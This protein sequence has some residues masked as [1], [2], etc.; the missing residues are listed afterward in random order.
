MGFRGQMCPGTLSCHHVGRRQAH[1]PLTFCDPL[2][3]KTMTS[4][5]SQSLTAGTVWQT[6]K[7]QD[8][9]LPFPHTRSDVLLIP[10]KGERVFPG[11]PKAEVKQTSKTI[12]FKKKKPQLLI[13]LRLEPAVHE[14][15]KIGRCSAGD[16]RLFKNETRKWGVILGS[17]GVGLEDQG[18]QTCS[19]PRA[20]ACGGNCLPPH[21][22]EK[23]A[24]GHLRAC[25]LCVPLHEV[26]LCLFN[27]I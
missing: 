6:T 2:E 14:A 10:G 22:L 21:W 27:L 24:K 20:T 11:I 12:P 18:L 9:P 8:S 26:V 7:P 1:T 17:V 15:S 25:V 23:Q 19:P 3:K 16:G 5:R 13:E 4:H